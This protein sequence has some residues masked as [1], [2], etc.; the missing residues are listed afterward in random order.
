[1]GIR[2]LRLIKVTGKEPTYQMELETTTI[3][4]PDVGKLIHQASVRIAFASAV[5]RL[6]PKIKPKVWEQ[7]VQTML[8]ALTET[9]GGDETDFKGSIRMYINQY[10]S[11]TGFIDTIENQPS[12]ALRY[13]TIID[14]RIAISS[15]DLQPHVNRNFSQNLSVKAI[16]SMLAAIGARNITVKGKTFRP[17]SRWLLPPEEFDPADFTMQAT[18]QEPA[19]AQ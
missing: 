2:I 15:S 9:E 11:D 19:D 13:P 18:R 3:E 7:L 6:I 4:F 16:A 8:D 17:Q 14:G 12:N 5:N 1:L 10:L